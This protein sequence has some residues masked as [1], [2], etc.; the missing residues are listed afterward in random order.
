MLR[1]RARC[2][3]R[4]SPAHFYLKR[5]SARNCDWHRATAARSGETWRSSAS[6]DGQGCSRSF[7]PHF[8]T[9]QNES[10]PARCC[11][12]SAHV[13]RR[14]SSLLFAGGGGRSAGRGGTGGGRNVLSSSRSQQPLATNMATSCVTFDWARKASRLDRAAG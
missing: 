10:V 2:V 1:Q 14:P 9:W 13:A 11:V 5:P 3:P 7:F 8:P 4:P 6:D 12:R